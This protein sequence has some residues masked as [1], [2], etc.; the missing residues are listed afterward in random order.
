MTESL[1]ENTNSLEEDINKDD[2]TL[3]F[4]TSSAISRVNIKFLSLYLPI[5]LNS[6][7]IIRS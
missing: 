7:I 1:E 6:L 3:D 4:T 5:L 2:Y